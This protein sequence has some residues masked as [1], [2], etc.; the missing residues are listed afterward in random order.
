MRDSGLESIHTLDLLIQV[1]GPEELA[2]ELR[3]E[4]PDS[5]D[6]VQQALLRSETI[7]FAALYPH[8]KD[9]DAETLLAVTKRVLGTDQFLPRWFLLRFMEVDSASCI[10]ALLSGGR[11]VEAGLACCGALRTALV[12]IQPICPAA[13]RNAPLALADLILAELEHH[14]DHP[15]SK[16]VYDDLNQLINEYTEVV[17]RT[18]EDMK[19]A[20]IQHA[21]VN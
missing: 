18:S 17:I 6:P 12:N 4:D 8:L 5:M 20:R 10:R 11:A 15:Q 7:D 2:A 16:E 13:P 14:L 3:D 19:V 1:I 21:I 9:A